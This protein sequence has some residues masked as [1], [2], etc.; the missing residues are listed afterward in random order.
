MAM[1][2]GGAG[3]GLRGA[4]PQLKIVSVRETAV[5]PAGQEPTYEFDNYT[6]G[7]RLCVSEK[8][9][10]PIDAINLSLTS[11]LPPSPDQVQNLADAVA[12]ASAHNIAIVAA[13]G[14]APGAVQWPAQQAGILAVGAG[15]P[16]NGVCSFSATQGLTLYAPGCNLDEADPFSDTYQPQLGSSGT[17]QA[18]AFTAAVIVALMSYD[19]KLTASAAETLV[20]KTAKAGF[21]DVAA[22]FN[23]DNLGAIV[24]QGNANIPQPP[25]TTT[26]TTTTSTST[27][28]SAPAVVAKP[29]AALAAAKV[30]AVRWQ[31]GVLT[32]TVR[33][34]PKGER[35]RVTLQFIHHPPR[36]LLS[37]RRTFRVRTGRPKDVLIAL[38]K[39]S[40]TS[41]IITSKP[42]R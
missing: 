4:W 27:T 10:Y 11:T 20:L 26:T 35:L 9:Q 34:V 7:I 6:Q 24:T 2:A 8:A 14:N 39:G 12:F 5:P 42:R 30:L 40:Q 36:T 1:T 41:A 13:A 38:M 28:T 19:P 33:R 17:S 3:I 18:S 32:I 15:D 29:K 21:L 16:T 37:R 25:P 23:A 22:A 31:H